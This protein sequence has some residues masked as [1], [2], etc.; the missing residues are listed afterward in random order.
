MLYE[1]TAA[2]WTFIHNDVAAVSSQSIDN[3]AGAMVDLVLTNGDAYEYH[4]GEGLVFLAHHVKEACAGQG[5][6][7]LL[8]TDGTLREYNDAS[9]A[10]SRT[11]ATNIATIDAGLDRY[12]VNMVD[13]ISNSGVFSECSDTSGWHSLCSGAKAI[14]AGTDGVSLVLLKNGN[15]YEFTEASGGFTH[16]GADIA[17][18]AVGTTANDAVQID[19]VSTT[20]ITTEF[21]AGVGWKQLATGV[22]AVGKA[23]AGVVDIVFTNGNGYEDTGSGWTALTTNVR[24]Q[25]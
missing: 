24:Q 23:R 19:L 3:D 20:G 13:V 16:L 14:S 5:V 12:G 8:G 9:G 11:L 25:T 6:S 4:D 10:M 1:H 22:A 2:G 21:C 18:L 17:Q 15:A 7:Y